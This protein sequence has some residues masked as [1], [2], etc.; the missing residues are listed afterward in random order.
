MIPHQFRVFDSKD[1]F[2]HALAQ[3]LI[4][5][6]SDRSTVH[7]ALSGGSTPQS[8][9]DVLASQYEQKI[10]WQKIRFFWVDER[11][12][13]PTHA[14]SNYRMTQQHLL[15]KLPIDVR[16]VFR[17]KGEDT[18]EKALTDYIETIKQNVPT[19][20]GLPCFDLTILGMGDDGHTASIFPHEIDLWQSPEICTIG[21]HPQTNQARVTLTG[22]TINNS[23]RILFMVTGANKA[24]KVN[25]IF[26][27]SEASHNYPAS[28]VDT[29]KT[30]WWLDKDAAQ[31]LIK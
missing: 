27:Q 15:S 7:I 23:K 24:S 30:E 20:G 28:L 25:E 16:Q 1:D 8:I 17:V 3:T 11:C 9:F 13:P 12:V 14:K 22:N 21:H 26:T 2:A 4:T 6:T 19:V 29:K 10:E 31:T 5:L 18:P